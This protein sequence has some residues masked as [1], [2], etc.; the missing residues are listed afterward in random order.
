MLCVLAVKKAR[1]LVSQPSDTVTKRKLNDLSK[2]TKKYA[3]TKRSFS[4][5]KQYETGYTTTDAVVEF[6][7]ALIIVASLILYV[8]ANIW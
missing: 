5:R 8:G 2:D 4:M 1:A 6:V 3:Q 7:V